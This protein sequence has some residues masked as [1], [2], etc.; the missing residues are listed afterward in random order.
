LKTEIADIGEESSGLL[1]L[2]PVS[3]YYTSD[4]AG[5]RQY[6]LIA[7]EVAEVLPSLVRCS[8]NGEPVAVRYQFLVPMLVNEVQKERRT[9][10]EQN[11]EIQEIKAELQR[12]EA[13]LSV[14]AEPG[15]TPRP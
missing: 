12:L 1:K 7:E 6:G 2:R 9:I 11:R 10:E 5:V 3:F 8:A 14:R 15:T 4:T 13:M